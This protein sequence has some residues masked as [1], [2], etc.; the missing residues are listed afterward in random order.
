MGI[1]QIQTTRP[2]TFSSYHTSASV[3]LQKAKWMYF[4]NLLIHIFGL[5]LAKKYK[6]EGQNHGPC[7]LRVPKE[8][9]F[10]LTPSPNVNA[11]SVL[12]S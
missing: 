11:S 4:N 1:N 6:Q 7:L 10:S 2:K 5:L 9:R 12:P 3:Q 8:N